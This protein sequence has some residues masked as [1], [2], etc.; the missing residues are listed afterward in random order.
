MTASLARPR[1]DIVVAPT[2]D[3]LRAFVQLLGGNEYYA[4]LDAAL[5][6]LQCQSLFNVVDM[7]TGWKIDFIIRKS[8]AFSEEEFRRHAQFNLQGIPLFVA[9]AEGRGHLDARMGKAAQSARQ[10]R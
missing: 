9:S 1:I 2:A 5:E 4:D 3:Q 10:T 8:R 7:A 6:A